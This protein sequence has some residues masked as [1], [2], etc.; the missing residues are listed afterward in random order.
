V[1]AS[2]LQPAS[3]EGKAG[4]CEVAER[5]VVPRRPGNAGGGKGPQFK[6]SAGSGDG[7]GNWREPINPS[8]SRSRRRHCTPKR[9]EDRA[10][11]GPSVGDRVTTL[12]ESRMREIRTSGSMSGMW[13]RSTVGLVR[14][15]QT[16]GPANRQARPKPPRHIST[17]PECPSLRIPGGRCRAGKLSGKGDASGRDLGPPA[18]SRGHGA[19]VPQALRSTTLTAAC[20]L[21]KMPQ[22]TGSPGA[23]SGRVVGL[24]TRF[25]MVA[26]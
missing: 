24:P 11:A 7:P 15:R 14:H 12:S 22:G 5:P 26:S 17:L 25:S 19:M 2:G 8:R 20:P 10:V 4:P 3:R 21:P 9:R 18:R 6:A 23:P 1:E 16:K 13:K